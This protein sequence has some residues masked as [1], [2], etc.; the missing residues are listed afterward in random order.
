MHPVLAEMLVGDRTRE[1][2][3]QGEHS[4]TAKQAHARRRRSWASTTTVWC[5]L[6]QARQELEE[7]A[8]S[9]SARLLAR[10]QARH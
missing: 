9:T 4:R 7:P 2:I 3:T 1:L 6:Q 8:P 5:Q 10:L